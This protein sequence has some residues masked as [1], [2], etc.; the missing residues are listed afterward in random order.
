MD[1]GCFCVACAALGAP[2]ARFA[3]QAQHLQHPQVGGSRLLLRGRRRTWSTSGSFCVAGAALAAPPQS[4]A[5]VRRQVSTMDAGCFCVAGAALGAHLRL[6]LPGRRSTSAKVG[7]SLATSEY[8]GRQLLLR[9][10]CS[11]CSTSGSFFFG[12]RSTCSTSRS[13][14]VRR[15]VS[16]MLLCGRCRTWSTSGSS[17]VAG[18]ALAAPQCHFAWQVQHLEHL[19][20]GPRKSGD[21]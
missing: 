20:R 2:Q 7:R 18:A 5:E 17:C 11:T 16:T 15:Q 12:R 6:V 3:C 10:R 9:G 8:Y 4:S 14:E 13:A 1:A 19:Q 21:K